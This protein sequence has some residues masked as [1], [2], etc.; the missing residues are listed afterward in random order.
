[1]SFGISII[2][3]T[4]AMEGI[5]ERLCWIYITVTTVNTLVYDQVGNTYHP[6]E[7]TELS[8]G[9]F[10]YPEQLANKFE[11]E[12]KSLLQDLR[13]KDVLRPNWIKQGQKSL[14]Q[15]VS[16]FREESLLK[17]VSGTYYPH[18]ILKNL[19]DQDI[20]CDSKDLI[21]HERNAVDLYYQ[22]DSKGQILFNSFKIWN[23]WDKIF[24]QIHVQS[25]ALSAIQQFQR[26]AIVFQNVLASRL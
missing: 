19:S 4:A 20:C 5:Y 17:I 14:Q 26:Y 16:F 12:Q 8:E 21:D 6:S 18:A 22:R 2:I 7:L 3:A 1:M 24:V 13:M 11:Y 25:H 10:P 9:R 23:I 15:I